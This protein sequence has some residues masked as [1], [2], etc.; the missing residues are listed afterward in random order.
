MELS[1]SCEANRTSASQEIFHILWN[2]EVHYHIH[3]HLSLAPMLS[4]INLVHTFPSHLDHIHFNIIHL[5]QGLLSCSSHSGIP[6]KIQYAFLFSLHNTFSCV[7]L[8]LQTNTTCQE[9]DRH[10]KSKQTKLYDP[11]RTHCWVTQLVVC[12]A[13]CLALGRHQSSLSICPL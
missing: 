1:P 3:K 13:N 2:L 5:C 10:N 4:Q 8:L 12:C 11:T 6:T 7:I 9:Y